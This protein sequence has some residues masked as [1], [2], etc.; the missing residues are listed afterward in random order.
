MFTEAELFVIRYRINQAIQMQNAAHIVIITDAIPAAKWIFNMSN[1][2]YQLHSIA[3]SSNIRGFFQKNFSNLI[4]FWDCTSHNRWPSYS[5]VDKKS[6]HYKIDS[7]LP[8]KSLWKFSKKS[9]VQFYYPQ[10]ADV[11]SS[12]W[13]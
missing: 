8:S 11:L 1:H 5:L 9:R 3:I 4:L 12:I 10:I 7:I 2:P 13:L 6:K